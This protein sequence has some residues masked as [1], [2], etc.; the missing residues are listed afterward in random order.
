MTNEEAIP[1]YPEEEGSWTLCATCQ[2]WVD[3]WTGCEC[4]LAYHLWCHPEDQHILNGEYPAILFELEHD[5]YE[6]SICLRKVD[7]R[8]PNNR[9]A[10]NRKDWSSNG[11]LDESPVWD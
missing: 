3:E 5:K 7:V 8:D 9:Q 4:N 11:C 6:G 1:P 2:D 10:R